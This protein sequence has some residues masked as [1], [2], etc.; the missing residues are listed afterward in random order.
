MRQARWV[1]TSLLLAL[2]LVVGCAR[3]PWAKKDGTA[4]AGE[5]TEAAR[6]L[7]EENV[8]P[9]VVMGDVWLVPED[10]G[11]A[12]RVTHTGRASDPVVSADGHALAYVLAVGADDQATQAEDS[13]RAELH[14]MVL[15]TGDTFVAATGTPPWGA[16]S[17][18]PD[19][20]Y[21]AWPLADALQVL[22]VPS[23]KQAAT[24][25]VQWSGATLP[26]PVWSADG[27]VLYYPRVVDGLPV[28]HAL[29]MGGEPASLVALDPGAAPVMAASTD[30]R[31][32]LWQPGGLVLIGSEAADAGIGPVALPAAM[33]AAVALAWSPEGESLAL[34]DDADAL[35]VGD[36]EG[37]SDEPAYRAA[38]L[39]GVRWLS[40]EALALWQGPSAGVQT[41]VRAQVPGFS[42]TALGTM[43]E[44][45]VGQ[46][47]AGGADTVLP[48]VEP[49]G[50]WYTV[51]PADTLWDISL[52]FGTTVAAL[53]TANS[54]ANQNLIYVGQQLWIPVAAPTA[55]LRTRLFPH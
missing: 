26:A 47:V 27:A 2:L 55:V 13:A 35:W 28:L 9:I 48:S 42:T 44:G 11:D 25:A 19:G 49:I 6:L 23:G 24:Y 4:P 34:V 20:A 32:A 37:F 31:L 17:W 5:G 8:L 40:P 45:A 14:V 52:R 39:S 3:L 12:I 29:P 15:D 18:S 22:Q 7:S 50:F 36:T 10:G 30:G 43:P 38:G 54:I 16:P 46:L 33:G 53:V 21:L 41:L 1:V 51:R